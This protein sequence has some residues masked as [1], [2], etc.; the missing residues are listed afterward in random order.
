M[1]A[2]LF[3]RAFAVPV[4]AAL[5]AVPAAALAAAGCAGS[6]TAA[7]HSAGLE[8]KNL[9]VAAVPAEG[10]A[11]LY[12]AQ[13]EGL[14][15]RAGLHVTIEATEDTNA[16]IPGMLHGSIDVLSGQYTTYIAAGATGLARMRILAAGYALGPDVQE[17]MAQPGS[18]IRSV[19]GLK[20]ATIAV[21]AVNS[22]TTDLLYAALVPYGVT[23]AQVR[24]VAVPFPAMP[25]AL[26]SGRVTAIYE[27]EPYVTEAAEHYGDVGVADIDAGATQGF[28]INGYGAL[29]SWVAKYPHTAAA[30]IRAIEQGNTIAE[31][32]P[33]A[34]Q[35]AIG[36]SLHLPAAVTAVMAAGTYPTVLEPGQIQRVADLMLRYGQL[37][38]SF[39]VTSIT[40]P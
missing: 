40:G 23:P 36:A 9:V 7:G 4:I 27:V 11:G 14:F 6:T 12:I 25:A 8:K 24:V 17:I 22:V 33:T 37:H 20:G 10:A 32:N 35:R 26:A 29:A 15:A 19:T 18:G 28:P 39:S 3:R 30:F 31:T 5:T 2:R 34:R 21:N 16:D 1:H 13:D 38:R